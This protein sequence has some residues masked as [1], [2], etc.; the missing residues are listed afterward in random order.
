M[1]NI[2]DQIKELFSKELKQWKTKGSH[3][4]ME[5]LIQIPGTTLVVMGSCW[6]DCVGDS[7]C[8]VAGIYNLKP[9]MTQECEPAANMTVTC[10]VYDII[11]PQKEAAIL[12]V[13]RNGEDDLCI[14]MYKG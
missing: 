8:E 10:H 6:V 5:P 1:S 12:V 9:V 14:T 11:D 2:I 4:Y 13:A 3:F 7:S